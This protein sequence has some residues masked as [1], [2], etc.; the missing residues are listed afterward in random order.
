MR[1]AGLLLAVVVMMLL[2]GSVSRAQACANSGN[3]DFCAQCQ[4]TPIEACDGTTTQIT[5]QLG[6]IGSINNDGMS[7]GTLDDGTKATSLVTITKVDADTIDIG[8][9]NTT[10]TTAT[11]TALFMNLTSTVTG[12]NLVNISPAPTTPD[13]GICYDPTSSR[14]DG[15][16]FKAGGF[17]NFDA[18]ISNSKPQGVCDTSPNGGNPLEILAGDTLTFWV[19]IA[20]PWNLCDFLTELSQPTPPSLLRTMAARFQSGEQGGSG[21]IAPCA[22]GTQLFA[23]YR[24]FRATGSDHRVTLDWAT[25]LE[26]DNAGFNVLRRAVPRGAWETI[27]SEFIVG[28]GDSVSGAEYS[29]VDDAAV[30]GVEYIYRI[31]DI[32]FSGI[33]NLS[34]PGRAVAN[35]RRVPVH[36][37]SPDYGSTVR[38]SRG[39][40]LGFASTRR[41]GHVVQISSSPLFPAAETV[42]AR[43]PLRAGSSTVRLTSR[44]VRMV[45][46]LD[47]DGILYWRLVDRGGSPVSET[48]RMEVQ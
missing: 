29:F 35:P 22:P 27:N 42:A 41:G 10:C 5:I 14:N 21:R 39:L 44:T 25:S 37:M 46:R 1:R 31:E 6:G 36:L 15:H 12:L 45:R 16:G 13:W 20:G 32:D 47:G 9:T 17:G 3:I 26:F 30:N 40:K 43:V 28:R 23:S 19:D 7:P 34:S 24:F 48:F 8:I 38:L 11:V 4:S 33:D 18:V 2:P